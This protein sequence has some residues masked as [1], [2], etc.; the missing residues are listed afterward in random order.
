MFKK[1]LQKLKWEM[2]KYYPETNDADYSTLYHFTS[3]E[4]FSKIVRKRK[5]VFRFTEGKRFLDK[6]EGHLILDPYRYVCN[7]LWDSGK[8]DDGFYKI[9]NEISIETIP[10]LYNQRWILSL[11]CNGNSEYMKAKYAPKTGK[12]IAVH[13][14]YLKELSRRFNEPPNGYFNICQVEYSSKRLEDKLKSFIVRAFEVYKKGCEEATIK[15]DNSAGCFEEIKSLVASFLDMMSYCYKSDCF[16][17][18]EEVRIIAEV[19]DG[20]S[21]W[22]SKKDLLCF[23]Q[24][25]GEPHLFMYLDKSALYH[26]SDEPNW[27]EDRQLNKCFLTSDEIRAVKRKN[28]K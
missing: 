11:S 15:N 25:C 5:L 13:H 7:K 14:K 28:D 27:V 16:K 24:S 26:V 4:S 6:N 23:E 3:S 17:K 20:F 19:K 8:I 2:F 18:E 21:R 9:L 10:G 1:E 12:I 22:T